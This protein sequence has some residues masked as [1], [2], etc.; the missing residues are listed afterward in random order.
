MAASRVPHDVIPGSTFQGYEL[1]G[2]YPDQLTLQ[3][4]SNVFPKTENGETTYQTFTSPHCFPGN[5][6]ALWFFTFAVVGFCC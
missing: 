3:M 2:I 5:P 4:Y 1:Y 6:H